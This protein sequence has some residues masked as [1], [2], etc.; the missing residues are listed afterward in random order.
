M[1]SR[2]LFQ[3][4]E[5]HIKIYPDGINPIKRNWCNIDKKDVVGSA[6]GNTLCK[7]I[8]NETYCEKYKGN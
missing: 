1:S 5:E 3:I 8:D 6:G 2:C 7:F 4:S